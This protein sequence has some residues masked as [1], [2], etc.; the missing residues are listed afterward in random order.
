MQWLKHSDASNSFLLVLH[1]PGNLILWNA[2]LGLKVWKRNF[3]DPLVS[4]AIDPFGEQTI[5]GKE[6]YVT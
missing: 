1:S 4:F 2:A 6:V 3:S 5:T